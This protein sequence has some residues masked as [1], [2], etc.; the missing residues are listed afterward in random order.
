ME[1]PNIMKLEDTFNLIKKIQFFNI[2]AAKKREIIMC[3]VDSVEAEPPTG[4]KILPEKVLIGLIETKDDKI[5]YGLIINDYILVSHEN[6]FLVYEEDDTKKIYIVGAEIIYV[7]DYSYR[8]C[9]DYS[10]LQN[11]N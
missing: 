7:K 10:C 9:T 8:E 11:M 4:E 1:E 2:V 6:T 3:T 5:I